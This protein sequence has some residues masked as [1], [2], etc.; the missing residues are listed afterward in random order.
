[1]KKLFTVFILLLSIVV[2]VHA[3]DAE[4]EILTSG[5]WQY[6]AGKT[7]WTIME[8]T[9]TAKDITIPNEFDGTP[10][11]E[12]AESLFMN[13]MSLEK[14]VIPNSVT[15][16]GK[17]VFQGCGNLKEATL[18]LNLKAIP[19]SA[20]EYCASLENILF[21]ATMSNIGKAAFKDCTSLSAINLPGR[22]STV[23]E[24]AFENCSS[25]RM[26]NVSRSLSTVNA[27]AFKGTPWLE[28]KT[29]EFVYIGRGILLRYNGDAA[30]VEIPYGTV[31]IADAFDGNNKLESV[32]IPETV[33]RI[34]MYSFRDAVNLTTVNFPK[35]LTSIGVGAFWGCRRLE[36]VE[37]PDSLTSIGNSA[38]RDCER[39]T[40][41][42]IPE[43][44]KNIPYYVAGN[45]ASLTDVRIPADANVFNKNAFAK[46]PNVNIQIAAG[47]EVEQT[48]IDNKIEYTYYN[49]QNDD[50]V[51]NFDGESVNIVKY[52]GNLYDVE[53]PAELDGLPVTS[54]GTAAFQNNPSVRR[55]KVPL[56][57]KTIGDWAFSYM[58][59]LQAVSL[60][61]GLESIGANAFTGDPQ[62]AELKLPGSLTKIGL[63]LLDKDALTKICC[64][65]G[66]ASYDQMVNDGYWVQSAS[67]CSSDDVLLDQWAFANLTVGMSIDPELAGSLNTPGAVLVARYGEDIDILT[68]P[69]GTAN[70]T[71]GMLTG[72]GSHLILSVP[73]SVTAIA[74][75]ILNDHILTIVGDSGSYAEQ[76][77][78]ENNIK[79][80]VRVNM[81]L[82][83]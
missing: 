54:I 12:L 33:R 36:N 76:F 9:G 18:S 25:L 80:I 72:T 56:S 81:W 40:S 10:V 37:L 15:T 83:D 52:V 79:F 8:Y 45:C 62:L 48:L 32:V 21:P 82:G 17:F 5:D 26:L 30:H 44:V 31:A 70:V 73:N 16:L 58:D 39:L 60:Q 63:N 42:S 57:V 11:T 53:I 71:V 14:V 51:Y 43:N 77:A 27:N 64:K 3:Q 4:P 59:S 50:F 23:G 41:L 49:Q 22:V 65:E 1:M 69:A 38:F 20:F 35:Y 68:I 74:P 78:I 28:S 6:Q 29:D 7:G 24:S 75:E 47:S 34:M 66:T 55:V 13:Y 19:E 61:A 2:S 67:A 46:S